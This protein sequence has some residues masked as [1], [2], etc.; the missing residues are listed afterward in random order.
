MT[1]T[2]TRVFADYAK[3]ER[4]CDGWAGDTQSHVAVVED[5]DLNVSRFLVMDYSDAAAYV[6]IHDAEVQYDA[7]MSEPVWCERPDHGAKA[8]ASTPECA[9]PH[10][11]GPGGPCPVVGHPLTVHD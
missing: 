6:G 9:Y 3:A 1:V 11:V 10:L 8:H 5:F 4:F 2:G 7:D